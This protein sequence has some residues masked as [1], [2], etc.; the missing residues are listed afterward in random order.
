MS[1][2]PLNVLIIGYVWPEPRSSAAGT[3]THQLIR[4]FQKKDDQNE[5]WTLTVA[6]ASKEN[7]AFSELSS[8]G[9]RCA[10]IQ[11]NHSGFD[12]WIAEQKFDFVLFDRF[13][14]EEQFGWRVAEASPGTVRVLDTS[15]LHF[16]RRAR[17][18]AVL[19]GTPLDWA[20]EDTYREIASIYR[21]DLTLLVSDFER[22]LLLEQFKIPAELL[23]HLPIGYFDLP[24]A[25][26]LPAFQERTGF[27]TIGNFR[28]PPNADGNRWLK[29]EIWPRIRAALP[30]AEMHIYGAYPSRA[31]MDLSDPSQGF[32]VEGPAKDALEAL[33]KHRV[34]LAPLRFGAGIKG[35]I[36]DAWRAGMPVTTTPIGAEGMSQ[37]DLFG[38]S[39]AT[40]PEDF[41][42]KAVFLHESEREWGFARALGSKI[43]GSKLEGVALENAFIERLLKIQGRLKAHR[44][45][46][47]IGG[48]LAQQAFQGTKYFSK[49]IEAK[50]A[51]LESSNNPV[52]HR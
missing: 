29:K 5:K 43:L 14:T 28:H 4:A 1:R 49:W 18:K 27:A 23:M 26:E 35:K 15:D 39:V 31:D 33:K 19:N 12:A 40:T 7:D 13:V 45:G 51:A 11:L 25:T 22:D 10:P 38:G 41:A 32:F 9:V 36:A 47:F 30:G 16:L 34:L 42:R 48:L 20:Q 37:D 6:S 2:A 44:S 24:S 3:R 8:S 46:N 17:Q 52:T 50:T 21:S